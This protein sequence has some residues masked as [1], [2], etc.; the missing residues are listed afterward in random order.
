MFANR[1]TALLDA[2]VLVAPLKRNLLLSLAEAEFFRPRWSTEILNETERAIGRLLLEKG[3]ADAGDK[4][5]RARAAMERAFEDGCVSGY[6]PLMR[7]LDAMLDQDDRH[8]V[9]AAVQ[10]R[11]STIVTDN[12]KHFPAAVL[13]P[14]SLEVRSCDNFLADTIDL[15]VS[16]AAK[17]IRTMRE[18]LRRPE[19]TPDALILDLERNG[20]TET[21]DILRANIEAL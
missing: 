9:A 10:T 14:L 7:G 13:E 16:L 20:L 5:R 6:E 17:A 2:C 3:G 4:A 1:F 12:L 8:V 11:A 19:K 15:N 21:A 18:R